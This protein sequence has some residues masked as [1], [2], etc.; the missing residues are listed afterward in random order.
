MF[1]QYS[2]FYKQFG[3]RRAQQL[4]APRLYTIDNLVFSRN[5]LYHYVSY[6]G[7]ELNPDKNL[8]YLK[9]YK[10]RI[11]IDF[12]NLLTS[13]EGNP[14]RR[15]APVLQMVK[16]F[17]NKN[18][19]FRYVKD[20]YLKSDDINTLIIINYA[21]TH[22]VYKYPNLPMSQ[23]YQWFNTEKT[24]WN[25]VAEISRSS[26][27]EQ[28]IIYD[29]PNVLPSMSLLKIYTLKTN[30]SILRVFDSPAKLFILEIWKW[31]DE[32]N[33][34]MSMLSSLTDD[35]LDKVNIVFTHN[36]KWTVINLGYLNQWRETEGSEEV[37]GVKKYK[38]LILQ[39]FFLKCL[40]ELI[41]KSSVLHED[42]EEEIAES[43]N[44]EQRAI[45]DGEDIEEE[46]DDDDAGA[47]QV[48]DRDNTENPILSNVGTHRKAISLNVS[49]K[50]LEKSIK[51]TESL[52]IESI[53]SSLDEELKELEI[54]EK[55]HLTNKNIKVSNDGEV[56]ERPNVEVKIIDKT[57][58]HNEIY[59]SK[60]INDTLTESLTKYSEYGSL[61]A[62][63]VRSIKTSIEKSNNL[64]DPYNGAPLKD[65]LVMKPETLSIS[66][67]E[68]AL[69]TDS[70]IEDKSML[71]SSLKVFDKKY[72]NEVLK[73]DILKS[74]HG[75]QSSGVIVEEYS[76]DKNNSALGEFESHTIKLRP[77]DGKP[78]TVRFKIPV[79]N[80]DS[81]Y[82]ANGNKYVLRKQL[83]DLP[84]RKIKP[85]IV[86]LSSYYGKTFVERSEFARNNVI[87]WLV[88]QINKIYFDENNTR[89]K[90]FIGDVYN[91][92]FKAPYIYNGLSKH[93][94]SIE[95]DGLE[96]NFDY[97]WFNSLQLDI[98]DKLVDEGSVICGFAKNK[99]PIIMKSDN[100]FYVDDK[101]IG[102]IYSLLGIDEENSPVDY[103]SV[104]IFSKTIPIAIVMGYLIGFEKLLAATTDS[105]RVIDGNR[106]KDLSKEEWYIR[107]KDKVYV[108]NRN[109]TM[110]CL[111]LNGL[112]NYSKTVSKYEVDV[113]N[114]K[115]IYLNIL[116]EL[117]LSSIYHKEIDNMNNMFIDPITKEVLEEMK[118]PVTFQGLLFKSC[119]MLKE[120]NTPD[121]QD[122]NYM[123]IRGYERI[124]GAIYKELS[125]AIRAYRTRNI[126]SRN[127][128]ELNPYA[129]WKNIDTDTSKKN[130]EDINPIQ[131]LKE[132]ESATYSGEGGRSKETMTRDTRAF[133]QTDIGVISE[134]TSDSSDAG[135][136]FYLTA[137]PN[138]KNVRGMVDQNASKENA[139]ILSTSALLAPGSDHDDPKRVNFVSIQQ[140]HTIAAEGYRQPYLQTGYEQ[141]ISYRTSELFSYMAED[142]G[143]VTSLNEKGIIVKYKNG[144]EKGVYLGRTYGRAEGSVYPHDIVTTLKVGSKFKKGDPIAYNSGFFE[145][146]FYDDNKIIFKN[147]MSVKVA[148]IDNNQT[149][150][151]SSVISEKI[152]NKMTAKTT[153]VKSYILE[154]KQNIRKL[155]KVGSL[156]HPTETLFIIEDETTGNTDIFDEDTIDSLK[157]ISSRAPSSKY[158]GVVDRIEV[159]YNGAKEDM[160]P[161]LKALVAY[162]D[163]EMRD[164][165]KAVGK[166]PIDGAVTSDYRVD[167]KPLLLDTAEIKIY[168]SIDTKAGIGDKGVFANQMKSVVGEVITTDMKTENGD[169]VDAIFSY[170]SMA[171][172][173]IL[174]PLIIG[175]TTSLLKH[176]AKKA[177]SIYEGDSNG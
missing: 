34:H 37:Q 119:D 5:A 93:F 8:P 124:A 29:A 71:H 55:I 72:I 112:N 116:E 146:D 27:R 47:S 9:V 49:Y 32:K 76:V 170:R 42:I 38:P 139:N 131:N 114:S 12:V 143:V 105:F 144:S 31:L 168:I 58:I 107:F 118:M 87:E 43:E 90:V 164:R 126:R 135:V 98:K 88:R 95:I 99:S 150:E 77:I 172:R 163:K 140:S 84:I 65:S 177:I 110:A 36:G 63:D 92:Y 3:V 117:R 162:S 41:S 14:R 151:D 100:I 79:I 62:A 174:S 67:E 155:V 52:N 56:I 120:Y 108:F 128:V 35:V 69:M 13:T 96:L 134:A 91:N 16:P 109:D 157:R 50:E 102:T 165:E 83:V 33:R 111:V 7:E 145:R 68:K 166:E 173:V 169:D 176:I 171:A 26:S 64:K 4:L 94:K 28:Y 133:H 104:R 115:E 70:D 86:A 54:L 11:L 10:K 17:L 59:T 78:S 158:K 137:N 103:A 132:I 53:M 75:I 6:D 156:V 74:V 23:Y 15:L 82:I 160:S 21:Y 85:T 40:I 175:T 44:P 127:Q 80:S 24:L 161:T 60:S 89:L 125:H 138:F 25:K 22:N 152:S 136:N 141:V 122:M 48:Q 106:V 97:K 123:R 130:V 154:F 159:F 101:P 148:F 149:N 167:G 57:A 51:E 153:K 30:K 73:K 20:P 129:V 46:L 1:L 147:G 2:Y 142:D 81:T 113:F 61:S 66:N 45:K 121:F 18:K 19:E 39:K